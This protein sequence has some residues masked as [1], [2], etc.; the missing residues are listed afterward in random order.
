MQEGETLVIS[1]VCNE[2][3]WSAKD[4]D[5]SI[6]GVGTLEPYLTGSKLTGRPT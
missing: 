3:G 1:E 4:P 6:T 5:G 2:G